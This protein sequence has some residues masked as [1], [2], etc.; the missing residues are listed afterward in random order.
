MFQIAS[1]VKFFV[2]NGVASGFPFFTAT[3][4]Q[5]RQSR[6]SFSVI[7]RTLCEDG[8][9]KYSQISALRVSFR[10]TTRNVE[11]LRGALGTHTS[12]LAG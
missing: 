10:A 11:H 12:D 4:E 3:L 9:R 1:V 7:E 6:S 8:N 2:P 5:L